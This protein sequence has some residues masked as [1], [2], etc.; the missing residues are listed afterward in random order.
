MTRVKIRKVVNFMVTNHIDANRDIYLRQGDTL[1]LS[2]PVINRA[3]ANWKP[4]PADRVVFGIK[5]GAT[6]ERLLRMVLEISA[7]NRA[8]LKLSNTVTEKLPL[9]RHRYDVR[10]IKDANADAT[11]GSR[12]YTPFVRSFNVLE[13]ASEV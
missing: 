4:G 10:Y 3:D 7:G 2:I 11:D 13:T 8:R 9:G 1:E 12:V 5:H 6:D